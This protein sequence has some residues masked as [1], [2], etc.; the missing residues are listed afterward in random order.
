MK[1]MAQ[2][3]REQS[4]LIVLKTLAQQTD[5]T[6]NSDLILPELTRFGIRRDRAW[7]H[8]EMRWLQTMGALTLI[9]AG[10]VLVATLTET[11]RQHLDRVIA[12]EGIQR[13][14]R[15]GG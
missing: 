6:L 10:S 14:S 15:P 12:I 9:E 5:E 7:L 13:P 8:Q 11:G 4:R 2:L 3:M 1:D